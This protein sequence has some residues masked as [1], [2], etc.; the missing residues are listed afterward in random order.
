MTFI[1]AGSFRG[2]CLG[3]FSI[4]SSANTDLRR[5]ATRFG[6]FCIIVPA[7]ILFDSIHKSLRCFGGDILARGF[8]FV[9]GANQQGKQKRSS[10]LRTH[11]LMI[12]YSGRRREIM[13]GGFSCHHTSSDCYEWFEEKCMRWPFFDASF[14]PYPLRLIRRIVK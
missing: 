13:R 5:E 4:R 12:R 14:D 10:G 2:F 7:F 6:G 9:L 3:S 8:G 11:Q 1:I